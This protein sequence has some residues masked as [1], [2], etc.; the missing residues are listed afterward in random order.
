M[1]QTQRDPIQT[2]IRMVKDLQR[3]AATEPLDP[4]LVYEIKE[5]K[6][7]TDF[8]YL[9]GYSHPFRLVPEK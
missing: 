2:Y 4:S 1:T 3:L 5:L 7:L 8:V 9:D 6:S